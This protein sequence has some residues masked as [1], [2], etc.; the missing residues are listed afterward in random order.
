M[1]VAISATGK[2]LDSAVDPRFGRA[3]YFLIVDTDS[4]ELIEVIDNSAAMEA[5]HGAGIN[6]ASRVAEAGAEAV[7]TGRVGPKAFAVFQ[8][9]GIK[10]CSDV[11]GTVKE[12]LE[13]FKQGALSFDSGPTSNGHAGL[14][15][16]GGGGRGRG[17]RGFGGGGRQ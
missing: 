10:V 13:K 8:A 2:D 6:A 16:G 17:R 7:L 11:S 12:A 5:A 14:G 1:K 15:M 3:R 4:G 9:A